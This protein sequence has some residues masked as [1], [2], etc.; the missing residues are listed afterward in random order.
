MV[1]ETCWVLKGLFVHDNRNLMTI[2][3][4]ET[5]GEL[6][7]DPLLVGLDKPNLKKGTTSE[8][9]ISLNLSKCKEDHPGYRHNF[10]SWEK[11]KPKKFKLVGY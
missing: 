6:I 4:G 11:R 2:T 8:S 9:N 5:I 3:F 7:L 1:T 10:Y